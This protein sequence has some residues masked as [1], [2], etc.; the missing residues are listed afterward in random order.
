VNDLDVE[1]M[2]LRKENE[3]LANLIAATEKKLQ[4]ESF[5]SRAKPEVVA[6]ERE[7]LQSLRSDL[8]KVETAIAD[9]TE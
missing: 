5:V 4:N 2:R 3:R 6:A 1:R 7:K 8:V 9:L